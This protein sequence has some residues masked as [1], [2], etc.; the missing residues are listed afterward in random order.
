MKK[1]ILVLVAIILLSGCGL[2]VSQKDSGKNEKVVQENSPESLDNPLDAILKE[3]ILI[4][5]NPEEAYP[6][7]TQIKMESLDY[8][9]M[10]VVV[11]QDSLPDD[12]LKKQEHEIY[13]ERKDGEGWKVV[14]KKLIREECWPGRSCK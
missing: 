3:N 5:E 14:S 1:I 13:L 4:V 12:V 9:R 8:Y 7:M 10:R 11:S 2:P 6:K